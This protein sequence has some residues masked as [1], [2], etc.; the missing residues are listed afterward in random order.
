[1]LP[2]SGIVPVSVAGVFIASGVF[3]GIAQMVAA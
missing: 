2:Y 1:V 3:F